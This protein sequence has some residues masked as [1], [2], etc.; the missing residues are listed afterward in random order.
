MQNTI[1]YNIIHYSPTPEATE[2]SQQH[3]VMFYMYSKE[4]YRARKINELQLMK[5]HR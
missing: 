3:P 5:D 1:H 2:I 4:Y